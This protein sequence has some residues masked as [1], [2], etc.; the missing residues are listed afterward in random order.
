MSPCNHIHCRE[1]LAAHAATKIK[2]GQVTKIEC[3]SE[4]CSSV[5][6]PFI[7]KEL[8]STELFERFDTLL[9]QRTLDTMQDIVYCPRPTCRCV[10]VKEQDSYMAQCPRCVFCFCVLCQRAWH[11]I[12]PCKLLS[13]NLKE[14]RESW[15]KLD[16][17][18]RSTLEAQYGKKTLER[19][20][21]EYDS[22]SWLGTN[23]KKCPHCNS[24]IQKTE[25]CNKMMCTQ[26]RAH[27]C[28]LCDSVLPQHNPYSHF[29]I[30]GG[31][32]Q[33]PCAGKLFEGLQGFDVDDDLF[34]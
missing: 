16:P 27:F 34:W 12:S 7:V 8:V 6:E 5:L 26:C 19:A 33:S 31:N 18:A 2:D 3:P 20:F 28:W 29:R 25:G 17:D 24:S 15:E 30:V 4:K 14:L 21:Q 23:A 22:Y 1:C 32:Y 11:G 9:L 10:T 13:G